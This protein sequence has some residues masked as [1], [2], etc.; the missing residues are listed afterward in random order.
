MRAGPIGARSAQDLRRPTTSCDTLHRSFIIRRT[1]TT[2]RQVLDEFRRALAAL[3][4]YGSNTGMNL[5]R[6]V[7]APIA[8]GAPFFRATVV[9][10]SHEA[11]VIAVA[12]GGADL[13]SIDCVSFPLL[14]R[15]RPELIKRVAIVAKSSLSPCL[16][17]IASAR[18]PAP[19]IAAVREALFG[20]LADPDLAEARAALGLEHVNRDADPL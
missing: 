16:P 5:F 1:E 18:L 8:D 7:I 9:T 12:E 10:V 17:F 2:L 3:N 4:A 20:A 11:S 15:G 13:A 6:A 14:E 19:T